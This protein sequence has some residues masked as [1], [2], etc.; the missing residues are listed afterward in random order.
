MPADLPIDCFIR[1]MDAGDLGTAETYDKV[2]G[3]TREAR[4]ATLPGHSCSCALT[5]LWDDISRGLSGSLC[6]SLS[7]AILAVRKVKIP[8]VE[9]GNS[10]WGSS[11]I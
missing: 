6:L 8:N 9:Y 10:T 5:G 4:Y 11:S 1:E 3:Y 7:T 2:R